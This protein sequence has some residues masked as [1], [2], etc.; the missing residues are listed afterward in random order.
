MID[1]QQIFITPFSDY[2]FMRRALIGC[3]L[4]SLGAGPLGVLLILRRMSLMG[5]AMSHA[6]LPG[7]AAGFLVGGLSVPIMGLGGL[8]AGLVVALLVGL[9]TRSTILR[10]DANMAA[11]YLIALA[12]GVML[13]SL[14]GNAID[15]VHLLF[16]SVLAIDK[17]SLQLMAGVTSVTLVL[18]ALFYR[19]ILTEAFD[20]IF[21]QSIGKG[22]SFFHMLFLVLVVINLIA[23]FQAL[24][25]LM[26]VGLMMLPAAA[27]RFWAQHFL[28]LSLTSAG[29]G[30]V[31]GAI[32]LLIS[33][34]INVPSGPAIILTAGLVYIISLLFGRIGSVRARYFPARH[35]E[36]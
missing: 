28:S 6:V 4:L 10:E 14:N 16:G 22:G 20:P 35:L 30:M 1:L 27:S 8:I 33:Y 19:P 11:F 18:F 26:A 21:M 17:E 36:N 24:G 2:M 29:I 12:L 32:G 31:S 25:T 3:V 5:E 23:G 13:I 9:V 15:L 34:H 7:I